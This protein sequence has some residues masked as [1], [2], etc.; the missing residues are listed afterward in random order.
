MVRIKI[1]QAHDPVPVFLKKPE[2]MQH[3]RSNR[4]RLR[5]RL[6]F[7]IYFQ[8]RKTQTVTQTFTIVC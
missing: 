1:D 3:T 4:E 8:L 6:R 2:V 7:P 5:Y